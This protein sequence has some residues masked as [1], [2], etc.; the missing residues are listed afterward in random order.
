MSF[1]GFSTNIGVS[2]EFLNEF[3]TKKCGKKCENGYFARYDKKFAAT[4]AT[5]KEVVAAAKPANLAMS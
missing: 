5:L 1:D 2:D 4:T 3:S